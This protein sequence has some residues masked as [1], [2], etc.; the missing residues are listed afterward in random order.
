MAPTL[1]I[2]GSVITG[3][4]GATARLQDCD[5][6]DEATDDLGREQIVAGYDRLSD[7]P[8]DTTA[9]ASADLPWWPG[10]EDG[11]WRRR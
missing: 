6:D 11:T 10:R 1:T 4:A 5:G 3:H 8:D 9:W 7:L 2:V